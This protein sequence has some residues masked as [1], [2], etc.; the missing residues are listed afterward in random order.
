VL[1]TGIERVAVS[2]AVTRASRATE[3]A[4][5]VRTLLDMLKEPAAEAAAASGSRL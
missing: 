1:A 4:L 2:G 5:A 3:V